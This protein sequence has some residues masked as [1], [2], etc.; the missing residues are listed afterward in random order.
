MVMKAPISEIYSTIQGE[1]PYTGEGQVFVRLAGCPL[2]CDYCDTRSSLT[3]N[4]HSQMTV[5]EVVEEVIQQAASEN[6]QTVSLTG[7]EPLSHAPF[8]R[9]LIRTLKKNGL[10]IY[11]ET[12]GVHPLALKSV[13]EDV[14]IIAMDIKL[15]TACGENYWDEHEEFLKIGGGKIFVKIVIEAHSE[16]AEFNHALEILSRCTPLPHLILQPVTSTNSSIQSASPEKLD[17]LYH[18]A[19]AGLPRVNVMPQQHKIWGIR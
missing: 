10:K 7:G 11:L 3:A 19:K 4:G 9:E 8:V 14:D 12:A 6:I 18:L 16:E 5:D 2:R 17:H 1:G 15:P 13:I